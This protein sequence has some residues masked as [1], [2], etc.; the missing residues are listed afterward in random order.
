MLDAGEIEKYIGFTQ[1][2][3]KKLCVKYETD[4]EK[5]RHWYDGY[6]LGEYHIYN[7]KAVVSVVTKRTFQSYWS[8]TGSYKVIVPLISKNF[9]GLKT[10]IIEML[11]GDMVKIDTG[12]F[13]NDAVN[14]SNRDDVIT[15]LIHLGYL[16]YDEKKQ[17]AYIP[18]EEVRQ[19]LLKATRQ[20]KWK[21]FIEFERQ[22]EDLQILCIC[23]NRSISIFI[24][25]C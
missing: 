5:V 19:E 17:C 18:N 8:Q 2:E 11:S 22:A 10:A 23:L 6:L 21:K 16:A 14:F 25:H 7:P 4:F 15:F 12:T 1:D 24:R 20:K 3:V 9:D 13:Q